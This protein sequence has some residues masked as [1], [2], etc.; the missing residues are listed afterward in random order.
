MG[1]II[2]VRERETKFSLREIKYAKL[3]LRANVVSSLCKL[4]VYFVNPPVWIGIFSLN[5]K[6]TIFYFT[7]SARVF[8]EGPKLSLGLFGAKIHQK[9]RVWNCC[10]NDWIAF[11]FS[12][13]AVDPIGLDPLT[14]RSKEVGEIMAS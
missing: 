6:Y 14:R 3:K 10:R 7:A 1:F 11:D 4:W 2:M 12:S 13:A 9:N 8:R 5:R